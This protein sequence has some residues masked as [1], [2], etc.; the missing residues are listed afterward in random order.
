MN[1]VL[2]AVSP[3]PLLELVLAATHISILSK[4]VFAQQTL[5]PLLWQQLSVKKI[6]VKILKHEY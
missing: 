3:K 2:N 5:K 4:G 1:D 6:K